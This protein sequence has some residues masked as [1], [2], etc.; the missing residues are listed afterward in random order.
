MLTETFFELNKPSRQTMGGYGNAT[1]VCKLKHNL[2]TQLKTGFMTKEKK[3]IFSKQKKRII[4]AISLF[5]VIMLFL[6]K[7][8]L[9]VIKD[10]FLYEENTVSIIVLQDFLLNEGDRKLLINNAIKQNYQIHFSGDIEKFDTLFIGKDRKSV[11]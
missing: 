11:V 1:A 6:F 9:D 10:V 8:H 5:V 2:A 7:P 4:A 3:Q